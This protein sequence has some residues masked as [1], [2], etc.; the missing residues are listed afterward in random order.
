M[1]FTNPLRDAVFGWQ[2]EVCEIF[3]RRFLHEGFVFSE[4]Q[5]AFGA[6]IINWQLATDIPKSQ[7]T[8]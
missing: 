1:K 8:P 4:A 5:C 3:V 7:Q 6:S 2:P